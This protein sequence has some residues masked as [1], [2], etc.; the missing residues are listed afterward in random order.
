M[1]SIM[2][3][4]VLYLLVLIVG[5]WAMSTFFVPHILRTWDEDYYHMSTIKAKLSGEP[6]PDFDTWLEE[7]KKNA[8]K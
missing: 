2:K 4:V 8:Q 7:Q 1:D 5:V 3:R 6:Y